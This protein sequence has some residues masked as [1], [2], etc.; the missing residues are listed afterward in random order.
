MRSPI[1]IASSMSCVT[2]ITVLP[3]S[4]CSR[5]SSVCR[6]SA[7]DRVERAERLVHQ[8]H[9]RVGRERAREA[10]ALA[11]PARELR[12]VARRV[13]GSRPDEL[14]QL[15]AARRV[16]AACPSRAAAAP[17]RRCRRR[18]C[19]GRGRSAGSRSRCR[20]AARRA[21]GRGSLR[22]SIR[23][24]PESNGISRLI[25]FS[26]VVL[27][28]PDGPTSTQNVP[29][30]ISSD[31]SSSAG[32]SRARRSAS[33][34][35]RRRSRPQSS[36]SSGFLIPPRPMTPPAPTSRAVISIDEPEAGQVELVRRC[37][38]RARRRPRSRAVPRRARR[39]C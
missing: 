21:A 38:R 16:S 24:S 5:R 33:S 32:C 14:E 2:K 26:A 1:V 34:R 22:P 19:A 12:R 9:R 20:A 10:D 11:L 30:G 3:T 18:S 28:P 25:I 6:R 7:R 17:C 27:P 29:A 39:R 31:R 35:G 8:E 13:A 4:R 37:R 15:R 36:R 23:I